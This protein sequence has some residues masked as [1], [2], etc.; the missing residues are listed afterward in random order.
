MTACCVW[1][2]SNAAAGGGSAALDTTITTMGNQTY[3]A[4]SVDTWKAYGY[5]SGVDRWS[6][7][8]FGAIGSA[9]Y[10]DGGSN[11]RT[12]SGIYYHDV[13]STDGRADDL[14]L[15]LNA[16]SISNTD[17]TFVSLEYNGQTYTR[18]SATYSGTLGSCSSWT[19]ANINPDGPTSGTPAVVINI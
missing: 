9:T 13:G 10:T 5:T 18:S 19:W 12:I 2:A 14:V 8:N 4:D 15:S 17:T 1:N 16:M 11:S 3:D 6:Y 7:G